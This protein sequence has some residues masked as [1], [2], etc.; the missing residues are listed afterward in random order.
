MQP[1]K[2]VG[3][4]KPEPNLSEKERCSLAYKMTVEG[5]NSQKT[6]IEKIDGQAKAE[7]NLFAALKI[8]IASKV[9]DKKYTIEHKDLLSALRLS[10]KKVINMLVTNP[11][12][13]FANEQLL[14]TFI[15]SAM[16]ITKEQYTRKKKPVLN[17]SERKQFDLLYECT[18]NDWKK[19]RD[20]ITLKVI[21]HCLDIV[22]NDMIAKTGIEADNVYPIGVPFSVEVYNDTISETVKKDS[23]K[24]HVCQCSETNKDKCCKND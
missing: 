24:A 23:V 13:E 8:A 11:Q 18:I 2:A 1:I 7:D 3:K 19:E 4:I 5:L 15:D 10:F 14:N 22:R 16:L 9:N 21:D 17:A 12:F 6:F 20:E